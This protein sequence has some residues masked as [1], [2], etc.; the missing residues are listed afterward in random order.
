[1]Y[2]LL[3]VGLGGLIMYRIDAN[4]TIGKTSKPS[5]ESTKTKVRGMV[6][7]PRKFDDNISLSGTLEANEQIEI[8]SEVSGIVKGINFQEGSKVGQGQVLF[9]VDDI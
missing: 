3:A 4:A 5:P 7:T 9:R 6:L 2:I 1:M 8:R